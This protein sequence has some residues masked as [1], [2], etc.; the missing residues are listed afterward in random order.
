MNVRTSVVVVV[1]TENLILTMEPHA[2]SGS[3][4]GVPF[5]AAPRPV[6]WS[7]AAARVKRRARRH[8]GERPDL[9]DL[10]RGLLEPFST[11]RHFPQPL[12]SEPGGSRRH[13][14]G[15]LCVSYWSGKRRVSSS[16]P[17]R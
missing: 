2:R 9:G 11:G 5:G 4:R 15:P 17:D 10:T 3:A 8:T 13:D 6:R 14:P 1:P 12:V 16:N 7:L